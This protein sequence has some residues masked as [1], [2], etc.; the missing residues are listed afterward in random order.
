MATVLFGMLLFNLVVTLLITTQ[1]RL[2]LAG[3]YPVEWRDFYLGDMFCS[4]TYS[5]SVRMFEII[6]PALSNSVRTWR[7]S[8]ASTLVA[9]TILHNATP[10][11][12]APWASFHVYP[13]FGVPCNVSVDTGIQGTNFPISSTVANT[14]QP[15]YST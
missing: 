10:R 12:C 7:Y 11:T 6:C 13:A 1:W 3:I 2:L 14:S 9:G 4:L 15:S 8:F 5:M